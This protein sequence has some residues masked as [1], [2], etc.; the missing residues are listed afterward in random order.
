MGRKADVAGRECRLGAGSVLTLGF[1]KG[2]GR[3]GAEGRLGSL[4]LIWEGRVFLIASFMFKEPIL[5]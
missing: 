1:C 4:P 2:L 3:T 5:N